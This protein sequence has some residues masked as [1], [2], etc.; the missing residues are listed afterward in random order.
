M[1]I[2]CAIPT[3]NAMI[4][5]S[6]LH[7]NDFSLRIKDDL[8]GGEKTGEA[9]SGLYGARPRIHSRIS[10]RSPRIFPSLPVSTDLRLHPFSS[11]SSCYFFLPQY[12]ECTSRTVYIH[13][14]TDY[15]LLPFRRTIFN[16][17]TFIRGIQICR[18]KLLKYLSLVYIEIY[19]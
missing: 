15:L 16:R 17:M 1:K 2:T 4:S 9:S 6:Q 5:V 8:Q 14:S 18:T 3:T 7:E 13:T 11:S 19:L 10:A 12:D